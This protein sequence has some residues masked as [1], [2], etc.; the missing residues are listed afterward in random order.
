MAIPMV[1]LDRFQDLKDFLDGRLE[2]VQA[3][4]F[5]G[6]DPISVPHQF[7][8]KQDIEISGFWTAI[9]AWG[10]RPVIL[11]KA[12]EL[13]NCMDGAPY[14]FIRNH[15]EKDR[16]RLSAFKHRTFQF[17]DTLYFLEFLQRHYRNF[18]SLE[19]AFIRNGSCTEVK[20]ALTDFHRYF[21]S[22]ED[23][24]DRTR[25]HIP[26]PSTGSSCK[27]LNM[28][29]R[30]MVRKDSQ[31]ID[32]GIWNRISPDQLMLPLDV[33]VGRTGRRLG[34]I[35][36]RQNDWKTVEEL[37]EKLSAFDPDDPAKYDL[38]LFTLGLEFG[39]KF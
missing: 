22:L 10:Q 38:A 29:L 5:I 11:Q 32:F 24:P 35:S 31:G 36:R 25:K 37:T 23:V 13:F 27:R 1:G 26:D 4:Q 20:A 16:L 6:N 39:K 28:F 34:L 3:S 21:F 12:R 9:L 33:H 17:T 8:R 30:W 19:D 7:S 14:D 18:E 2:S 15:E